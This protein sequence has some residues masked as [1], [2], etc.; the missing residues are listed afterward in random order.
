MISVSL[1][2][3]KCIIVTI[4]VKNKIIIVGNMRS[5]KQIFTYLFYTLANVWD[6]ESIG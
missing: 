3:V 5:R 2:R 1:S 4:F 6:Y